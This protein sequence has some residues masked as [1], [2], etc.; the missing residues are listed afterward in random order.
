MMKRVLLACA[1]MVALAGMVVAAIA[2]W[3]EP[4]PVE[5]GS[6]GTEIAL[7]HPGGQAASSGRGLA[8]VLAGP[9]QRSWLDPGERGGPGGDDLFGRLL[10]A[11]FEL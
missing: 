1:G 6:S 3:P 2:L 8:G 10:G 4:P 7:A 11:L 9:P 5:E